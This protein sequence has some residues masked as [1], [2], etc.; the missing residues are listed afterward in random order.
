MT[1]DFDTIVPRHGT[2]SI[3]WDA[4]GDT[5]ILPM[6]VAD[7]D[8][9]T[10]PA[11]LQALNERV[12]H[13]IFGYT[14]APDAFYNAIIKWWENRH[15]SG[16]ERSW[17]I[18]VP[19]IIPALSAIIRAYTEPGDKILVQSPVYNHF[20]ESI[21]HCGRHTV[22]NDLIYR[23]GIYDVDFDDLELKAADPS[24]K[25][26]LLCNPH[27]PVG[28]V[29]SEEELRRVGEICL[30]NSV[31]VVSDEIHSDLVF[32]GHRHVPFASL[33]DDFRE[34]SITCGSPSKTFNLAGLQV[35][36]LICAND[37]RRKQVEQILTVQEMVLLNPFAI[38]ALIA[39]YNDGE[40]WLEALK[41]YLYQN[42]VFLKD[43]LLQHLPHITVLPL[44]GTYLV[45]LDVSA[46][47][48]SAD[49]IAGALIQKEK[50]W[51]NAGTMYGKN[52]EG[53]LRINIACSR[54]LL[55]DGLH[56]L[57]TGLEKFA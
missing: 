3:K 53:F 1:Y 32:E 11:V 23:D 9:R 15:Q 50:L 19:G 47:R 24:V 52:G 48:K 49:L 34:G 30:K 18:T 36:Y 40:A 25:L 4:A 6:W 38:D 54:A 44:Q 5:D 28:R 20:F 27:N 51:L 33:D 55:V 37:G 22:S 26:L 13:G 2:N 45:W 14:L 10:A 21:E 29:W 41:G 8:F 17:V 31:F 12:A 57:K 16:I 7:M 39:A 46:Y 42:Y 35:A 43:F 56:R